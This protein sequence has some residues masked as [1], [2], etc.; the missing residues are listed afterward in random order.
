[1]NMNKQ[2]FEELRQSAKEM[3][4]IRK[5]AM[6]PTHVTRVLMPLVGKKPLKA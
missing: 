6:A 2:L 4:A 5:G 3:V 1:M